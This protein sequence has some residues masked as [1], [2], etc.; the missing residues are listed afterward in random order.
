MSKSQG[1]ARGHRPSGFYFWI[2][3]G[4]W[5]KLQRSPY[6]QYWFFLKLP[7][8]FV[9]YLE[10]TWSFFRNSWDPWANLHRFSYGQN[11]F[12]MNFLQSWDFS[13]VALPSMH[14][15]EDYSVE[16]DGLFLWLLFKYSRW[17]CGCW[18]TFLS[19]TDLFVTIWQLD[20][21]YND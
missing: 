5:M 9:L 14:S 21:N 15:S 20:N 1:F 19:M 17:F 7:H 6:M 13:L 11:P 16:Q 8:S 12:S 10:F 2:M 18:S 3:L 4:W